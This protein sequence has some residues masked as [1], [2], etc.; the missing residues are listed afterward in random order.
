M[1]STF[2][3]FSYTFMIPS[4]YEYD[5]L[6]EEQQQHGDLMLTKSL[7]N[8]HPFDIDLYLSAIKYISENCAKPK[9]IFV[10]STNTE[11]STSALS[12]FITETFPRLPHQDLV[13]C[14]NI[15]ENDSLLSCESC[16]LLITGS[17]SQVVYY[18]TKDLKFKT[19]DMLT[20][21]S[22]FYLTGLLRR[23]LEGHK[24]RRFTDVYG[25]VLDVCKKS[26]SSIGL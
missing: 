17:F 21:E 16:C 1:K 7:K 2:P 26:N 5:N 18:E 13:S 6:L 12:N 22:L 19:S 9:H 4:V 14:Q 20:T 25:T 8:D 15:S 11:V 24:P 23:K 10:T 3:D